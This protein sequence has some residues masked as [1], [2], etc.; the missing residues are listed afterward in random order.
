ME[1]RLAALRDPGTRERLVAELEGAVAGPMAALRLDF[2]RMVVRHVELERN[3]GLL[4]RTLGEIA[5]ERGSTPANVLIDLSLEENLGTAFLSAEMGHAD[6]DRVGWMLAHPCVHIG[7]SDGG[8]HVASFAT[9][10]DTGHLFRR[11]VRETGALRLEHAIK[12][13]TLDPA[14][15]WGLRDRGALRPGY[16]ADIVVFDPATIDRGPEVPARD[17]PGGGFRYVRGSVGVEATIVNGE[18]AWTRAGGYTDAR[19]GGIAG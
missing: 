16:G 5:S 2:G 10:G 19:P 4:G 12:K 3:R 7:A 11:Y 1:Q 6:A 15:I 18:V 14:T 8:A 13:L 9:Y 17:L